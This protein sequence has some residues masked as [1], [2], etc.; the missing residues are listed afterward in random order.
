MASVT[1]G[2]ILLA[3]LMMPNRSAQPDALVLEQN[4]ILWRDLTTKSDA[5]KISRISRVHTEHL[6]LHTE[7]F[8]RPPS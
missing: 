6:R 4:S 8:S 2:S 7:T 3:A 5:Q 1:L